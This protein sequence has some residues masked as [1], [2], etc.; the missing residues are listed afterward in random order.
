[1]RRTATLQCVGFDQFMAKSCLRF[2]ATTMV[3]YTVVLLLL[4]LSPTKQ[5]QPFVH[6]ER[7]YNGV[8]GRVGLDLPSGQFLISVCCRLVEQCDHVITVFCTQ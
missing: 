8:E 3:A 2:I 6:A 1:M 7:M 4:R 5:T